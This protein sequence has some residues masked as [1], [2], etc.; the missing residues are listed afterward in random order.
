[1]LKQLQIWLQNVYKKDVSIK[2]FVGLLVFYYELSW[3]VSIFN[4]NKNYTYFLTIILYY[5]YIYIYNIVLWV[6]LELHI[7]IIVL[8]RLPQ[9]KIMI[10]PLTS[11]GVHGSGWVRLRRFFDPTHHGGSKKIQPNPHELDWV[12]LNPW[13]GQFFLLLLLLNWVEKNIS[14]LPPELINKI[15]I[16]I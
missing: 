5:I 10:P 6:F 1:M 7:N 12:R 16:N 9:T 13:V 3:F 11:R 8:P 2:V 4:A 14:H 15:Y